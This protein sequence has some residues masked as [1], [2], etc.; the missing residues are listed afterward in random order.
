MAKGKQYNGPKKPEDAASKLQRMLENPFEKVANHRPKHEVVNRRTKG[1]N[2]NVAKAR[3]QV[4]FVSV[5]LRCVLR[6]AA[7][8]C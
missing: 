1:A 2:K 7:D 4:R 3:L 6:R 8:S 5:Q